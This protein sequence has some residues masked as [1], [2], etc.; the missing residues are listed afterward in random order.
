MAEIERREAAAREDLDAAVHAAADGGNGRGRD[1]GK[2]EEA[3]AA[4]RSRESQLQAQER[5]LTEREATVGRREA[6][7]ELYARKL[8]KGAVTSIEMTPGEDAEPPVA[9]AVSDAG[10]SSGAARR[11]NFWSR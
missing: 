5:R 9:A 7:L 10:E 3:L 6:D 11:L 2:L 1:A 8:Q 4:L